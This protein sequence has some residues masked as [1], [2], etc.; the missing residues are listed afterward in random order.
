MRP[1]WGLGTVVL[2]VAAAIA[3]AGC[4][5]PQGGGAAP[6]RSLSTTID[7]VTISPSLSPP[8]RDPA[9]SP[10]P[11][12]TGPAPTAPSCRL[13]DL[14]LQLRRTGEGLTH[15]TGYLTYKN[16]SDQP[17]RIHGWP[18][19]YGV[20]KTGHRDRAVHVPIWGTGK[21]VTGLPV[22]TLGAGQQ[23]ASA[24]WGS[25]LSVSAPRGCPPPYYH[26]EISLPGQPSTSTRIRAR[27]TYQRIPYFPSCGGIGTS[28]IA[29]MHT[30]EG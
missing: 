11:S 17:C 24:I 19:I 18:V 16:I 14:Q 4:G 29:T 25:D 27:I 22:I 21:N 7:G 8:A 13:T 10:S 30:S 26:F 23:V 2:A 15:I 5:S 9:P 28:P 6:A 3:V 12:R 1:G 20:T